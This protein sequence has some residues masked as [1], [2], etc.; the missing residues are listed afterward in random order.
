MFSEGYNN[1]WLAEICMKS[2]NLLT[3]NDGV[4]T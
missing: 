3:L 4:V 1:K 2:T